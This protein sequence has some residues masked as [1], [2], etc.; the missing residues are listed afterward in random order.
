MF[1]KLHFYFLISSAF[2][3]INAAAQ[4]AVSYQL[5]PKEIADLLL[6]KP[7]PG[8]SIDDRAEWILFSERNSYPSVEELAMPE[9]RIAG[10]RL[11]PNNYSPSRITYINNFSLKN[12]K[13]D[14]TFPVT[15]LPAPLYAS[16]ISWN[17]SQN[18]IAFTN[19][20]QKGVDLYIIDIATKKATKTNKAFL[21]VVLGSGLTWL[22]DNTIIYRAVTKPA[23]SAPIKPLMPKGPTVQQNLGK[24]APSPTYQDLIKSP[25]DEQLFEFYGT[26]Q[27]VKNTGGVEM[28][29]GKPA[30]YSSV[31]LSPDKTFMLIETIRKPFSYLVTANGFPS[32]VTV[33]DLT[34][35]AVKVLAE[36]PSAEGTPS[37]YDN[38]QNLPRGFDW[39]D[40]EPATIIWS[41]PLDSGLIKKNVPFHDAVYSLS[42]PFSGTEKEL[43]KTQTRFRG[44]QWGDANLALVM[45]GLRSK[46]T[47]KV[48]R[49][50]PTTGALEEL[51]SRNQTDAYGN[52]GTPVTTKNKYGR[53]VI[54]TI[55]NG[56]KLLMNNTVGSSDKGDLPF[57][58]KFDL[59]TKK[60][61]IIW[62]SAEGTF[63][64]V[65][66]VID[67]EK[68][69]LLTRKESQK[70]VPNYYIK[71]LV[72]RVA[73]RPVTAF[74]NPYPSLDGVVKEK[75]SYKRSDGVD[76]TGDLYLPKGYNKEK[77]GL[78]PTIIWAYPREFNSAADAA[79]IRGSKDK[80][81]T[82][83]WGSPIYWVTRGYAVLDNA[84]MP[85]VAKD[86]KK[87]NDTFIDQL[88][89]NAEAAINKLS[90]LGVGDRK[91]MAVGGHSYGA[92]MTANLL[93]HTNLFAA[94]I[95]RS[96]AYN[97]TL[98]PFGFQNEERTYWQAP[99]LYYEMSPFS[100]ADKIKTPLLLI[101]GDSDD[102][103]GTFPINSERLFAA[104]KGAGGTVRFV[105]L[106][107]EAHGYRGKENIL[108]ALWEQDQWLEKYV[109]NKK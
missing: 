14:K 26:S 101:H 61:E 46:Q 54:H 10:L 78:L 42:A 102:N 51:Y 107:Y 44:V 23:T 11:N 30:I 1:K 12:I 96:G 83:S 13:A 22:N 94:G 48:S 38:M 2:I 87:P 8:V 17:P 85:I 90:D 65:S 6:A 7:T 24:A 67:P 103:T 95:A 91:R 63:E 75:I 49:Y 73:D 47:S 41:K 33:T 4:D 81:T 99:Q 25:Y 9:Y 19:T 89:L 60:N 97:R 3:S 32:T 62:R 108:H 59:A 57:L 43:F 45:E 79:Q 15:G 31:S 86:G 34:G 84:E 39:R 93:A 29:I 82:I 68:L 21:N 70:L 66:D 100:Y 50:N 27:L 37:G 92:F 71:N 72:L 5:P 55:D 80:F 88:S 28:P 64:Y 76:L 98:T 16:N 74:S 35:K 36:L 40:D 53:S 104:I 69:V 56:T 77:D 109:K 18:K 105:F 20:T 106:P 52:P 58:A